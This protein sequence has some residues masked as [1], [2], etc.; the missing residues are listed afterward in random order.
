MVES[1]NFPSPSS[2]GSQE[3]PPE[4]PR[5]PVEP[6]EARGEELGIVISVKPISA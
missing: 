2:D 3:P 4:V 1:L 5:F 6:L